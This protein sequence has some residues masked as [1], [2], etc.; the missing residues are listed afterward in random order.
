MDIGRMPNLHTI[1]ES[2]LYAVRQAGDESR[3]EYICK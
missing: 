2:K 1:S 3:T